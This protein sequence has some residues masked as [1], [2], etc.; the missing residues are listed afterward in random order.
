MRRRY[1]AAPMPSARA[2]ALAASPPLG[3]SASAA[4]A[5][6]RGRVPPGRPISTSWS[7]SA[8]PPVAAAAVAWPAVTRTRRDA[9][10]LAWI[11]IAAVLLTIPLLYAVASSLVLGDPQRLVP[12]PEAA[13]ASYLALATTAVFSVIGAVHARA[14]RRSSSVPPASGRSRS[15]E[16]DGRI[17][18]VFGGVV[19]LNERTLVV[20]VAPTSAYGPTDLTIVPPPCDRPAARAVRRVTM[21]AR[22][23]ADD[24]SWRRPRSTAG[25]L[26]RDEVWGGTWSGDRRRSRREDGRL[27]LGDA[28]W[29]ARGDVTTGDRDAPG[30]TGD[31]A[32]PDP[33]GL[34]DPGALTMD[35]PP[36]S[37]VAGEPGTVVAEDLG[38]EI[39]DGA[40]A[41]HCR[42][43]VDGPT[44]MRSFL[45]LRWLVSG[46]ATDL[47]TDLPA[48]RGEL[49][50]WVFAD[51]E[52]GRARD[53]GLGPARR[54]LGGAG[55]D[56]GHAPG[57]ARR[58]RADRAARRQRAGRGR[59]RRRVG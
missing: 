29:R 7:A 12:S 33:F 21:T 54:R 37:V 36:R 8:F 27:R 23:L 39:I 38:F 35:G 17:A 51:G 1:A 13:Y 45:P 18:V 22:L 11:W 34:A 59:A 53:R 5:R 44:A 58:D 42:T 28:G 47:P 41:R 25:G 50:W 49:D 4:S 48:W 24:R 2:D 46:A 30:T 20:E 31:R 14:R 16:A 57:C 56:R 3:L 43:F 10:G 19:V 26:D 40:R 6:G 55:R 9:I 52:L 32:Q 15:P